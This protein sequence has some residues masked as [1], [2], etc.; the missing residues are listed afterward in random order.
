MGCQIRK[1]RPRERRLGGG[2]NEAELVRR[3]FV[4][5]DDGVIC[6]MEGVYLLLFY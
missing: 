6:L 1:G 5:D 4:K 3:S 2:R